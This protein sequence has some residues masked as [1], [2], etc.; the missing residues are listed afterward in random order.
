MQEEIDSMKEN[1]YY[2]VRY[3]R[4]I[5]VKD[6]NK[7]IDY[8]KEENASLRKSQRNTSSYKKRCNEL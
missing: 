6:L 3:P 2:Q 4:D 1:V 7:E 5:E 8:L